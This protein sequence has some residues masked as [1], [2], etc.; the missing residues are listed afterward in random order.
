MF[1]RA[2]DEVGNVGIWWK[3][4]FAEPRGGEMLLEWTGEGRDEKAAQARLGRGDGQVEELGI[5]HHAPGG[6]A[7]GK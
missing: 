7:V 3:Q 1:N 5:E 2:G 6:D 4:M